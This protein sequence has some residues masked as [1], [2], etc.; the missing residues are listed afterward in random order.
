MEERATRIARNEVL[1]RE[2]NERL[3]E[4]QETFDVFSERADF[5]CECGDVSCAEQI[6]MSF[7][8][9]E[10][11]RADPTLFAVKPGHEIGDVESVVEKRK[12]YDVVRKT[13]GEP[14]K[15]ARA[16]DPRS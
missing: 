1:F 2:L 15:L 10:Q 16:E 13:A 5:V 14:A 11:L 9:Y 6:T 8:E 7:G 3:N 12:G 4:L